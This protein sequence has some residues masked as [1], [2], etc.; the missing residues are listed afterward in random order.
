LGKYYRYR[1]PSFLQKCVCILEKAILSILV[2]QLIRTLI[3]TT[4]IDLILLSIF[5]LIFILF[6]IRWL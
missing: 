4:T 1:L 6:Y 2:F 5:I 3:I